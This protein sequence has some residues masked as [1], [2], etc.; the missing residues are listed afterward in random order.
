MNQSLNKRQESILSLA[1]KDLEEKILKRS[2][3][4]SVIGLGYVGLPLAIGIGRA[5]FNVIG[6]DTDEEKV[7]RI[8]NKDSYIPDVSDEELTRVVSQKKLIATSD[9]RVLEEVD[10]V[11]ICVPTPLRKTRDPDISYI[12]AATSQVS[13]YLHQ[14]QLI[15]LESTT[16]PGT[17]REIVL[18]ELGKGD[19]KVGEDFF[20]AFSPE[21]VDP[22][23]KEYTIKNTPKVVGGITSKCGKITSVFFKQIVKEVML[24]AST[25]EAEMTKLLENIFRSVNIALVNELA[26]M[27]D[28]LGIDIWNV[29]EA[30]STKPFGFMPFY[31]GPGLGGH[32][33]PIDP[34]YLSWKARTHGFY[35]KF[36][37]LAEEVNRNMPYYVVRKIADALNSHRKCI[38]GSRILVLGV[39]YKQDVGDARESPAS[40]IIE[41]LNRQG[42]VI[43]YNDPYVPQLEIGQRNWKSVS[44]DEEVLS[45]ADCVV[46]TTAHSCYNYDWIVEN[47]KLIIDTRNALKSLKNREKIIKI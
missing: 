39:A 11:S 13:R 6:I 8:N 2:A 18:P 37:E 42:A 3:K 1:D 34:V 12:I 5:G 41:L 19:L 17:T 28:K 23:N 7:E 29:I 33:L 4:V 38:N 30:A 14:G 22:G 15:I 21:R 10:I 43:I 45:R 20:L 27:C 32:C 46:I 44:L 40:D 47:A 36:I 26:L 9:Y 35:S 25:Q 31:P 24:V 16:F